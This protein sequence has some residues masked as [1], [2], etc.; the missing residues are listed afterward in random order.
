MAQSWKHSLFISALFAGAFAVLCVV[1]G[2]LALYAL[3][4]HFDIRQAQGVINIV[5]LNK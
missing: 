3:N 1:M 2:S 5:V 4:I